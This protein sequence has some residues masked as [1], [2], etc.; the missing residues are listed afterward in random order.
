MLKDV[1]TP[2][3][4]KENTH[5]GNPLY[6][7]PEQARGEPLDARSDAFSIGVLLYQMAVGDL[8][9]PLAPGWERDIHDPLLLEDISAMV[10]GDVVSVDFDLT[11]LR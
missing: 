7:A 3:A 9:R 1:T 8:S 11:R 5:L 6:T 10:E 4:W 2:D